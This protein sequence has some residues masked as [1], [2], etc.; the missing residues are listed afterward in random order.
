MVHEIKFE[1][2]ALA[3]TSRHS[4]LTECGFMIGLEEREG[5]VSVKSKSLRSSE[6]N[7]A[8]SPIRERSSGENEIKS[9]TML[10]YQRDTVF[11]EQPKDSPFSSSI[12]KSSL[13]LAPNE[14]RF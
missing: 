8:L 9:A 7:R 10:K 1:K 11:V 6:G 12:G 13:E 5:G 3:S 4:V 14:P 2:G